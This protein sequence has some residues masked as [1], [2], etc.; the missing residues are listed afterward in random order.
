[1]LYGALSAPWKWKIERKNAL[2]SPKYGFSSPKNLIAGASILRKVA[3]YFLFF[4][5]HSINKPAHEPTDVHLG[6]P[7][8]STEILELLIYFRNIQI[9][10]TLYRKIWLKTNKKYTCACIC[11]KNCT[12]LGPTRNLS[13]ICGSIQVNPGHHQ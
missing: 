10:F 6:C 5:D 9:K 13:Y 7:T 11:F 3:F 1:M 8:G 12:F 2:L 4:L